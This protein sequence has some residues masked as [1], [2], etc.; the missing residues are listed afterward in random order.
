V[1]VL[2]FTA[3]KAGAEPLAALARSRNHSLDVHPVA[4]LKR[5]LERTPPD[6]F[7]Y[8]DISGLSAASLASRLRQLADLAEGRFGIVDPVGTLTDPA[9]VFHK[10][11]VDYIGRALIR[12]P[13]GTARFE[14]A[15]E[16][17]RSSIGQEPQEKVIGPVNL[18][19]S[20]SDWTEVEYGKEYTF[21]MLYIGI[22]RADEIAR[23]LS[24]SLLQSLRRTFQAT[25]E[26]A[27]A[28][29]DGRIWVW[30]EYD[31]VLLFP[32]DGTRLS[33]LIPAA[34]FVLNRVLINLEQ[35]GGM[36][37]ISWRMGL[38]V[39]NTPYRAPGETGGIVSEALN[40]VFHLGERALAPRTF[41]LTG[42]AL[43]FAPQR[44]SAHFSPF[45]EFESVPLY[46]F[47]LPSSPHSA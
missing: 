25:L 45:S 43:A 14:R 20:G 16:A 44:L 34:R 28:G 2:L 46:T 15:M 33:A 11:G 36:T 41:A 9:E 4:E 18:V 38:H 24:E 37:P 39:G 12:K 17:A 7:V 10:G 26:Q 13:P 22:D 8:L 31:G 27:F 3:R 1:H 19:P 29:P 30:K 6:C 42:P 23:K 32:F 5:I 40:F 35:F 47:G 21:Q